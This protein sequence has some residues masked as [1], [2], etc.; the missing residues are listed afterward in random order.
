MRVFLLDL[1][2]LSEITKKE[3]ITDTTFL[4]TDKEAEKIQQTLDNNGYFWIIDQYTIGCSGK[5][6]K[7]ISKW[8]DELKAWEDSPELKA[9][10]HEKDLEKLWENIKV[11]RTLAAYTGVQV[12]NHWWHTDIES[13]LKYDDLSRLAVLNIF[14]DNE[15]WKTM[16][17][18]TVTLT[19]DLFK[20]LNGA[21]YEKTKQDFANADRLYKMAKEL[22]EPLLQ[23]INNGWS[24][25]YALNLN[26]Q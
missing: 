12:D 4:V 6:P 18:T 3:E 20:K 5:P 10:K 8:N 22:E 7:E 23:D 25:G 2:I 15:Q 26:E 9:E 13:R 21:I 24:I 14:P 17:N 1:K 16:D 19:L 11:R